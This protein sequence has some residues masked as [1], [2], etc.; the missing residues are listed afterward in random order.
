MF[1]KSSY[2]EALNVI[3]HNRNLFKIKMYNHFRNYVCENVAYF[4]NNFLYYSSVY[5][6]IGVK[7]YLMYKCVDR[8]II[9][10]IIIIKNSNK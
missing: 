7:I 5:H 10:I 8:F 6:E 3:L 4:G 1:I 9:I 2:A